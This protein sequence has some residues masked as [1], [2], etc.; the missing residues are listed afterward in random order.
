MRAMYIAFAA[1]VVIALASDVIL[2]GIGFGAAETTKA[3]SVR[4]DN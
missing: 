2:D 4:L 1:I 3:P